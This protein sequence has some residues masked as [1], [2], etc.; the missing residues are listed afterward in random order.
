MDLGWISVSGCAAVDVLVFILCV[1]CIYHVS[2]ESCLQCISRRIASSQGIFIFY[3]V[4]NGKHSQSENNDS[5]P[6]QQCKHSCG[7]IL[8]FTLTWSIFCF[9]LFGQKANISNF[10][11]IYISLIS[12]KIEQFFCCFW[13]FCFAVQQNVQS[14]FLPIFLLEFL[15]LQNCSRFYYAQEAK[16]YG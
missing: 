9:F 13:T 2:V 15:F 16:L 11:F 14:G 6:H 4:S 8:T 5:H 3:F 1:S 12:N 7:F 10:G